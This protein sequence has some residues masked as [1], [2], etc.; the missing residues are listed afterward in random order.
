MYAMLQMQTADDYVIA[1]GETH[2]VREFCERAFGRLGL[3]W[4]RY[5]KVD[6][7][8]YRP[9]EVDLLVGDSAKARQALNWQP[10]LTFGALV[11]EM[12]DADMR[13]LENSTAVTNFPSKNLCV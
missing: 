10:R 9:A 5:V 7:R 8:F 3:D 4:E 1:T 6:E 11:D 12:V 2:T 13:L